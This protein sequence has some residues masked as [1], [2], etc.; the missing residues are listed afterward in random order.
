ME[1]QDKVPVIQANRRR[2]LQA[3]ENLVCNAVKCAGNIGTGIGLAI[4][5]QIMQAYGSRIWVV[6]SSGKGVGFWLKFPGIHPDQGAIMGTTANELGLLVE[7]ND[8]HTELTT[9]YICNYN[10][11]IGILRVRDGAEDNEDRDQP[12]LAKRLEIDSYELT[13]TKLLGYWHMDNHH[14]LAHY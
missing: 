1:L 8:D 6:S 7:D 10:Q 5:K 9:F 14:L 13:V 4:A 2:V 3:F 12:W 11:R